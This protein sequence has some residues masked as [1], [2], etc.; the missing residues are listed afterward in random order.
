M[1][2]SEHI[3]HAE[4][5]I[6]DSVIMFADASPE[7][8]PSGACM[9][10]FSDDVD[11]AYARALERGATS[12]KDICDEPYGRNGGVKD[13]FGNTWWITTPDRG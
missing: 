5:K 11:A 10:I 3:M 9:F 7:Y 2:D 12:A 8:P 1:R 4:L 13:P 6:G